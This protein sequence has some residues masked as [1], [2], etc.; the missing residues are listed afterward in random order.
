MSKYVP[1][2]VELWGGPL[3]GLSWPN[4]QEDAIAHIGSNSVYARKDPETWV[5]KFVGWIGG[6]L[7]EDK[8]GVLF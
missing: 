7:K 1:E 5:F 4:P 8:E 2:T 3:D 6:P